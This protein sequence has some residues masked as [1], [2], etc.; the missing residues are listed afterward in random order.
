MPNPLDVIDNKMVAA[1][2]ATFPEK[3]L[4]PVLRLRQLILDTAQG[5]DEVDGVIE[6][7]KWGEPSYRSPIGSTIRIGWSK[8]D[9]GQYA[10]YFNCKSKLVDTI[11]ELYGE[12]FM[13]E[14]NRAILFSGDGAV[15]VL[16]LKHCIELALTYHKRK[17]LYLL[18]A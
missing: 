13:L 3:I 12:K 5:L 8:S 4:S 17:H 15:P 16:E 7:L 2:Y 14:G 9:P 6:T 11:R 1:V 18:G 10:L